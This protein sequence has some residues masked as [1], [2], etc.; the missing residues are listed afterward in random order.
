G[1]TCQRVVIIDKGRILA[2]DTT[3]RL[4]ERIQGA[5]RIL[6]RAAGPRPE[7]LAA[8]RALKEAKEVEM[9]DDDAGE[10]PGHTFVV[11][12]LDRAIAREVAQVMVNR[13]W[14]LYELRPITMGLEELFVHLTGEQQSLAA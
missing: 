7:M 3:A 8:L 4:T 13:G 5:T 6:V 11:T 12:S 9:R 10:Q 1:L 2:E 14:D